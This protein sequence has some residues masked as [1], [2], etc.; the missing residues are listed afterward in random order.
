M[1]NLLA[2][3]PDGRIRYFEYIKAFVASIGSKYGGTPLFHGQDVVDWSSRV[4]E[5]EAQKDQ[6]STALAGD[7][8]DTALV[9]YPSI[10]H[11]SKM[12]DDPGYVDVDRRF[13]QGALKDNPLICCTE[14]DVHY[15]G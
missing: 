15:E 3:Q 5:V 1:F 14:V 9:W 2:Y 10:W 8:V 11:F 6:S 4:S 7:W 12:L 13:K